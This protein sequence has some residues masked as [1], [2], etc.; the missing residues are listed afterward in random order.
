MNT[1]MLF[2]GCTKISFEN[3]TENFIGWVAR[4]TPSW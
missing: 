3:S 1:S 4:T 2:F